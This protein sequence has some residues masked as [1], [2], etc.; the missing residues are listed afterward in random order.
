MNG[1]QT[2]DIQILA[3]DGD[4]VIF[5]DESEKIYEEEGIK[6]FMDNERKK[7]SMLKDGPFKSFLVELNKLKSEL[8]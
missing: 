4:Y 2:C 7:K 8:E 6:A 1:V 5:S 3:I